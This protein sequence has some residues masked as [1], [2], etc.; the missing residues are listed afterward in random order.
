MPASVKHTRA[1]W[2]PSKHACMHAYMY[3]CI[4]A[5]MHTYM[6]TCITYASCG[7]ADLGHTYMHAYILYICTY[8]HMHI[9]V[10]MFLCI[11][12]HTVVDWL[13][14]DT[15]GHG[16]KHHQQQMCN[17]CLY[18]DVVV[19]ASRLLSLSLFLS[20]FLSLSLSFS[21]SLTHTLS[22]SLS[23]SLPPSLCVCREREGERYTY[24]YIHTYVHTC[25]STQKRPLSRRCHGC[26]RVAYVHSD[27]SVFLYCF[28][29]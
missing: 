6:H 27:V 18:L 29:V 3:T 14:S 13:P 8:I 1:R 9:H 24:T 22:L 11:H 4:H 7:L 16:C 17:L 23:L 12:S 25:I 15:L 5:H 28:S 19:V 10:C 26:K 21:L 20:L 2:V